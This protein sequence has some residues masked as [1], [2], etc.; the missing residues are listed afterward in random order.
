MQAVDYWLEFG[1]KVRNFFQRETKLNLSN[2]QNNMHILFFKKKKNK[3][4]TTYMHSLYLKHVFNIIY[5][6]DQKN[7]GILA[8]Y[9]FLK[10]KKISSH[11]YI[12]QDKYFL[13]LSH[14]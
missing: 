3:K 6:R 7:K 10:Y 2:T 13:S 4:K 8:I 1:G 14:V 11:F 5:F 12:I 9:Y